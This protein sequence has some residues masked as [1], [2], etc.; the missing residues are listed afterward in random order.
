MKLAMHLKHV[1][2]AKAVRAMRYRNED[3]MRALERAAKEKAAHE[4]KMAALSAA[5]LAKHLEKK[6]M[7]KKIDEVRAR[8]DRRLAAEQDKFNKMTSEQKAKW[9]ARQQIAANLLTDA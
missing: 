7:D 9:H 8:E 5:G 1:K 6:K 3:R 4:A 2:H